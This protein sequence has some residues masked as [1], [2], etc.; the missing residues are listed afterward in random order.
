MENGANITSGTGVAKALPLERWF[1]VLEMPP[2]II[3][4]PLESREASEELEQQT[5]TPE[6]SQERQTILGMSF[7]WLVTVK[8]TA[9]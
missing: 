3:K 6:A 5:T 7:S 1:A 4:L 2:G 9:S 8:R